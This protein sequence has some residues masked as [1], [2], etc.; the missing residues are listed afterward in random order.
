MFFIIFAWKIHC[1]RKEKFNSV[2]ACFLSL[3]VNI[4]YACLNA[5][6]DSEICYY[7]NKKPYTLMHEVFIMKIKNYF[8]AASIKTV[9]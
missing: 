9:K 8:I 3:F 5:F 7:L 4:G 2:I 6:F 1:L